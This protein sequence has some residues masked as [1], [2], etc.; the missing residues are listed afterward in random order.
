MCVIIYMIYISHILHIYSKYVF[1]CVY[2]CVY[3]IHI[4][5]TCTTFMQRSEEGIRFLLA[6]TTWVLGIKPDPST[7]N[8]CLNC[9]TISAD[10]IFIFNCVCVPIRVSIH[11]CGIM[12]M[13]A[14][15]RASELL[16]LVF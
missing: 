10:L 14:K 12:H 3:N 16:E 9:L 13:E 7:Y 4:Y 11:P 2:V 8:G 15:K 5:A 6:E 1:A